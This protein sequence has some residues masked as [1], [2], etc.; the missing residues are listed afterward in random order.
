MLNGFTRQR[1]WKI[2]TLSMTPHEFWTDISKLICMYETI[3]YWNRKRCNPVL[4]KNVTSII[5]NYKKQNSEVQAKNGGIRRPYGHD[6]LK[7][8]DI[9]IYVAWLVCSRISTLSGPWGDNFSPP[10]C[11]AN[12]RWEGGGGR[13][14]RWQ[15]A[16]S[17]W[18]VRSPH[19]NW[20]GIRTS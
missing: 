13:V 15:A 1:P 2:H 7:P 5:Q 4:K 8:T 19:P 18:S 17:D 9:E 6:P 20:N 3:H 11:H 16:N 12:G 14:L 10:E